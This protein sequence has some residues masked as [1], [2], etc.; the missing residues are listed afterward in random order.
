M[1]N[2]ET[3][4]K[5]ALLDVGAIN[6]GEN[7]DYD[8][9]SNVSE[10][11]NTLLNEFGI[12]GLASD[13][14][15]IDFTSSGTRIRIGVGLDVNIHVP[16][17][18]ID[19]FIREDDRWYRMQLVTYERILYLSDYGDDKNYVFLPSQTELCG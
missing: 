8:T 6:D 9:Y 5:G 2:T 12:S 17:Q 11:L 4:I 10:N 15:I 16:S 14:S 13:V 3:I 1:L 7:I 18:L 19:I